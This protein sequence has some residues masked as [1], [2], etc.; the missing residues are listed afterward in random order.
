MDAANIAG[1]P[2]LVSDGGGLV[3]ES[4]S[5]IILQQERVLNSIEELDTNL[6]SFQS[7]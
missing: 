3:M 5:H 4:Q 7:L 6:E 1:G 2:S